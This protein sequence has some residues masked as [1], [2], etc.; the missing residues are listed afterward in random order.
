[1]KKKPESELRGWKEISE[2]LGQPVAVLQ[3]WSKEGLPVRKSG[4]YTVASRDEL[5]NWLGR[6]SGM[7]GPAHIADANEAEL[8]TE[9]KRSIQQVKPHQQK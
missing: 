9:L 1:V 5:R 7:R 8:S 4:R 6:E 2:F 3:R